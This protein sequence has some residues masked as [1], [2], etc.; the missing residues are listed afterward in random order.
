MSF[1]LKPFVP[2][3]AFRFNK[4]IPGYE[5]AASTRSGRIP[6]PGLLIFQLSDKP[7]TL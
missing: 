7:A 3:D 5:L 4:L 2:L 1:A 6:N